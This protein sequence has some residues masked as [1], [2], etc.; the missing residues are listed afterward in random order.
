MPISSIFQSIFHLPFVGVLVA[1]AIASVA[2]LGGTQERFCPQPA[3]AEPTR[4]ERYMERRGELG[5]RA[6]RP[7]VRGSFATAP[8][9]R[10]PCAG[11]PASRTTSAP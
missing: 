11:A 10:A 6:D 9:T 5:F 1:D 2:L 4:I 8:G 3:P 7:Y